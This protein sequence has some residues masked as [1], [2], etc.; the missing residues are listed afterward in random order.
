MA[1]GDSIKGNRDGKNG[2]NQTYTIIGRGK[3]T[4]KTLVKEI[5]QGKHP[6]SHVINVEGDEYARNNPNRKSEDNIDD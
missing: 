3:V 4:R 5:K 2:E 1:K 6:D